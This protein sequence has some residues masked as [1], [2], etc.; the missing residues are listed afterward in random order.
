MARA[1]ATLLRF[2]AAVAAVVVVAAAAAPTPAAACSCARP[3]PFVDAVSAAVYVV[4]VKITKAVFIPDPI[5]QQGER[6]EWAA[7]VV[8][9]YKGC[10]P[11]T[12]SITSGANSALC[13]ISL[14]VGRE[15]VFL[16]RSSDRD[17]K[18]RVS[19]CSTTKA[20]P[21]EV[22]AN[23]HRVLSRANNQVCPSRGTSY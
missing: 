15:W 13:G 1:R 6:A 7:D 16:L 3:P 12:I 2:V 10:L 17:G 21:G 18:F 23:D 8:T 14:T 22:T 4:R 9:A 19:A 20:W 11:S 5:E